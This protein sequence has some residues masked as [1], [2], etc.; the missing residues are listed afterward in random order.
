MK[1]ETPVKS[2]APAKTKA[3]SEVTKRLEF[4]L[5]RITFRDT[6]FNAFLVFSLVVF[7]FITGMLVNKIMYLEKAAKTPPPVV[8]QN[9]VAAEPTIPEPPAVVNVEIGKLPVL[10]KKDAKLTIVEFSDFQCPFCKRYVDDAHKQIVKEYIDTGKANLYYRHFP[11]FSIHPNAQKA[12]EAAE[13]A[14]EQ[15]KFWEYH[16]LLFKDQDT[17]APVQTTAATGGFTDLAGQLGLDTAQFSSCLD[18]NKYQKTVEEDGLAGSKAQVSGTPTFF[19]NGHRLV[20]SQPF[21]EFKK[22]IDEQLK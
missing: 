2:K 5:P 16:D 17:W 3:S 20:G 10:G 21:S 6:P 19:I 1:K 13:C 7:A 4:R 9:P 18:T 8:A 11:L 22:L 15:G 14:N 12:G